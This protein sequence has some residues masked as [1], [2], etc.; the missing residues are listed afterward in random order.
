MLTKKV[1]EL[2]QGPSELVCGVLRMM[3]MQMGRPELNWSSVLL[4]SAR[5]VLQCDDTGLNSNSSRLQPQKERKKRIKSERT[6]GK[7]KRLKVD[8]TLKVD[9]PAAVRPEHVLR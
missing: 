3:M 9:E 2:E 1:R 6:P 7:K 5:C 4:S 8:T